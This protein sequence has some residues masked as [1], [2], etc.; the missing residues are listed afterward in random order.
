MRWRTAAR[1]LCVAIALFLGRAPV[2]VAGEEAEERRVDDEAP[3]DCWPMP[4]GCPSRSGASAT[5]VPRGPLECA[6]TYQSKDGFIAGEPLVWKHLVVA[7][8]DDGF[9]VLDLETGS[10][11]VSKRRI[12]VK[13]TAVPV[14]GPGF[15]L[16]RTA[17]DRLEA[18][19]IDPVARAAKSIWSWKA[20]GPLTTE[21]IVRGR[22]VF[23]F[24]FEEAYRLRVGRPDPV[25]TSPAPEPPA[26]DTGG[27]SRVDGEP[28]L[29][30][31]N[32]FVVT[33]RTH[34]TRDRGIETAV[35]ILR[36]DAGTGSRAPPNFV[37]VSANL[38]GGASLASTRIVGRTYG[39]VFVVKHGLLATQR[40]APTSTALLP[41]AYSPSEDARLLDLLVAP[42]R[43]RDRWILADRDEQ[44]AP[45]LGLT[46]APGSPET[47]DDPPHR[48]PS[49]RRYFFSDAEHSPH[50]VAAGVP[51]TAT[52]DAIVVGPYAF[53]AET[54]D[55]LQEL[56][57]D[58]VFRT[59]PARNTLLTV[60]GDRPGHGSRLS[61]FRPRRAPTVVATIAWKPTPAPGAAADA[62]ILTADLTV[63]RRDG[64]VR[65]GVVAWTP[66][67][68]AI[69][70]PPPSPKPGAAKPP[71]P[72]PLPAPPSKPPGRKPAAPVDERWP[73]AEVAL[74][75]D[76]GRHVLYA[77]D[78]DDAIAAM[79]R[80]AETAIAREWLA[81]ATEAVKRGSYARARA[82]LAEAEAHRAPDVDVWKALA[83]LDAAERK[84]RKPAASDEK[85]LD[86]KEVAV[87]TKSAG[88]V[89]SWAAGIPADAPPVLVARLARLALDAD[90]TTNGPSE[91]VRTRVPPG[92]ETGAAFATR[93]WLEYL[94]ALRT[95]PVRIVEVPPVQ[96]NLS[97]SERHL[98]AAR[99]TWR[100]DAVA[101]ESRRAVVITPVVRP[102]RIARCLATAEFV[103]RALESIFEEYRKRRSE[104]DPLVI[105]L[106][107]TKEEYLARSNSAAAE[108]LEWT[109]GHYSPSDGASRLFVPDGDAEFASVASTFAHELTHQW[110]D[111]SCPAFSDT[112]RVQGAGLTPGYWIEEGFAEFI[113]EG[114]VDPE[115]G[116]YELD[117]PVAPSID[118]VANVAG[119]DVIPWARLFEM[120][121]RGFHRLDVKQAEVDVPM[122]WKVGYHRLLSER[123]LFYL[124][125]AA[126]VR[127]LYF[128]EGGKHR[129]ALLDF[130]AAFHANR[131]KADTLS[132]L[133]GVSYPDLGTK[134]TAWC[135]EQQRRVTK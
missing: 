28:T 97:N 113:E 94:D 32:L 112:E 96:K 40:G 62:P 128:A 35:E 44:G 124:Q 78:P 119:K 63:V 108:G 25:W 10:V 49:L 34:A 106:Y 130:V 75:T 107:E 4:D 8:Y 90:A 77:G 92:I 51:V 65:T 117:S 16:A 9:D 87:R 101:F 72:P 64:T 118:V 50:L 86:A 100:K 76:A 55:V 5:P 81:F 26:G 67:A 104:T 89:W 125:S 70:F 33:E 121:V 99:V 59:V 115:A 15:V 98:G 69:S 29:V 48:G 46:V 53:D 88:T 73:L 131:A 11:I 83:E 45:R 79:R 127:Y 105:Y 60:E 1:W 120:D 80:A 91:W 36:I 133:L 61:A 84:P 52:K 93:D 126:A 85:A 23:V 134:V 116:R 110:M 14:V 47:K 122:R 82:A 56:P 58:V 2:A 42:V 132:T 27:P 19:S 39:E 3:L 95:T 103:V 41:T 22:D 38:E 43:W 20:P 109:L 71:A 21:P 102:G 129:R 6:W 37:S 24:S 31:D 135:R 7:P 30:A 74:I 123:L 68:D 54:R 17:P 66:G 12:A 18:F 13:T 57:V 114:H 111:L